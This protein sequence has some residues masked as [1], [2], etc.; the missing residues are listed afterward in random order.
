M[1]KLFTI[2]LMVGCLVL[3]SCNTT[4]KTKAYNTLY[5]VQLTTSAAY[6]S[7]ISLVVDGKVKTNGVPQVS[8]AFNK[9]Q[10]ASFTAQDL[11]RYSTDAIAPETVIV[12]S[13]DVINTINQ[14][15]K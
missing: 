1:K 9:F 15:S 7:Y 11:A 8:A 3:C 4:P 2:S 5:S 14:W 10:V 6:D 12:L 13:Q